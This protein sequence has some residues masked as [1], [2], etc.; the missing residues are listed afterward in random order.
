MLI[1]TRLFQLSKK[2][3][4]FCLPP[5][6]LY[7]LFCLAMFMLQRT[8]IFIPAT[9]KSDRF[10]MIK[11]EKD[12]DYFAASVHTTASPIAVIYFGG[13][14]EDVTS[15]MSSLVECFEGCSVYA[16]HYRGYG[17]SPGRPSEK[18]LHRDAKTLY[19]RVAAS[20]PKVIVVGRSL[21]SGVAVRLA[22]ENRV[23]RLLLVT[24]FDSLASVAQS[25]FP[26][27][28]V[29]L[30]ML[31]QFNSSAVASKISSPTLILAAA[32]DEIIPASSTQRLAEAFTKDICT[33]K[34]IDHADHNSL[35]LP[36][37]LIQKFIHGENE[38]Q[39][40]SK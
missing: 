38:T 15:S 4:Y 37:E 17:G 22:A 21:G 6:I 13:N 27:L 40:L 14:A 8:M 18:Q 33:Y 19:D 10:P 34:I 7:S 5:L 3:L 20:H 39:D 36:S 30:L 25:Q 16:M 31:D 28:P 26:Y 32:Q 12:S 11:I 35:E 29:K 23:D 24:P 1:V 9:A 2:L